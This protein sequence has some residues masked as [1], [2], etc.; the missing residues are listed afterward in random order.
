MLWR[1]KKV[2]NLKVIET[3][4][5]IWEGLVGIRGSSGRKNRDNEEEEIF[6]DLNSQNIFQ[7]VRKMGT[8]RFWEYCESEKRVK[9]NAKPE[10]TNSD[11]AHN[12]IIFF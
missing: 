8:F 12:E 1:N 3:W 6:E 9:R 5:V 4:K 7:D 2:K 11:I 10:Y